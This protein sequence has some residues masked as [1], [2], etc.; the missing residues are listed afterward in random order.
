LDASG[1]TGA[2]WSSSY[3]VLG[4]HYGWLEGTGRVRGTTGRWTSVGQAVGASASAE[5]TVTIVLL[6]GTDDVP[7]TDAAT[8]TIVTLFCVEDSGEMRWSKRVAG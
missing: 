2:N 7:F 4:D 5:G 6:V 3:D 8:E 1:S